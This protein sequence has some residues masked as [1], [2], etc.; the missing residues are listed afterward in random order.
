MILAPVA[1]VTGIEIPLVKQ[2]SVER[3]L[4]VEDE[5][6]GTVSEMALGRSLLQH[7]FFEQ[8]SLVRD[9]TSGTVLIATLGASSLQQIF[10]QQ[11]TCL[12]S[13]GF[14]GSQQV[15]VVRS[16]V[17]SLEALDSLDVAELFERIDA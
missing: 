5:V 12:V 11:S 2:P 13:I 16:L 8:I 14:V 6:L 1:P 9:V 15:G 7:F 3:L 4:S 10:L 17:A